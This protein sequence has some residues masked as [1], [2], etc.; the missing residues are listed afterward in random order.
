MKRILFIS[1]LLISGKVFAD[2]RVSNLTQVSTT[3]PSDLLY[4]A[5][6]NGSTYSSRAITLGNF[7]ENLSGI[8]LSSQTVGPYISSANVNGSLTVTPN[9][10]S[11]ATP[12]FGV[13]ISSVV[14]YGGNGSL[15]NGVLVSSFPTVTVPGSYGSTTISPT[16]TV[17]QYG[18]VV[19]LSSNSITSGGT[20]ST[21]TAGIGIVVTN[22]TGPNVTV[23]LSPN[24][25]DYIQ[26]TN[27]LQAGAT[28]YLSSGTV[29]NLNV[30]D[31]NG[32]AYPP[33]AGNYI[34]N[35]NTLQANSTFYTTMGY[36]TGQ[37]NINEIDGDFLNFY[38][39]DNGGG[40][41]P[42]FNLGI[43]T[44]GGLRFVSD[45]G[46]D[47]DFMQGFGNGFGE[48][49]SGSVYYDA[50]NTA[51]QSGLFFR[52]GDPGGTVTRLNIPYQGS[53]TLTEDQASDVGLIIQGFNSQTADLL[54]LK[55]FGGGILALFTNQGFL[56][57]SQIST[58]YITDFSNDIGYWSMGQTT[59]YSINAVNRVSTDVVVGIQEAS[60]QSADIL[61]TETS[62][63]AVLSGVAADGGIA[64]WSRTK[65]QLAALAPSKAGEEYYCSD[66]STDG[67][68]VSTGTAAG[69]IARIS[70]RT[71]VIN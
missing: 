70:A 35:Q 25:T 27:T 52:T 33:A 37:L 23:T 12:T 49:L 20:I 51:G 67:I 46:N 16:V 36:V 39:Y 53:T 69:S 58:Q 47:V 68:V 32:S 63:G 17:D 44:N 3:T 15:G 57:D 29:M 24:S 43:P 42:V 66:C 60:G 30:T 2:T 40:I 6:V 61:D 38:S 13:N 62:G 28:F 7:Q 48:G 56:L 64:P 26:N 45:G 14:T 50:G 54:E 10:T 4:E 8:S 1:I 31:I 19:A 65:A 21:I 55:N 5:Q 59:G 41:L 18:R 9:G 34:L 11:N 71:T 22:S